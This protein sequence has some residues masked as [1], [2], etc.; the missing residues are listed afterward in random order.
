MARTRIK[1]I[2]G[3]EDNIEDLINDFIEDPKNKVEVVNSI[4]FDFNE[5]EDG[6]TYTTAYIKK[7]RLLRTHIHKRPLYPRL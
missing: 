2:S 3:Y 6:D 1:L 5:D 7:K 4:T